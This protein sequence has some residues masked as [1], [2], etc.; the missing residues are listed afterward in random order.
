MRIV[1]HTPRVHVEEWEVPDRYAQ[2]S[3]VLVL[4]ALKTDPDARPVGASTADTGSRAVF[5][6]GAGA[7]AQ[8]AQRM[9]A[10]SAAV[11][12]AQDEARAAAV[13]AM[14]D[15]ASERHVAETLGVARNTVRGWLGK[16]R[17]G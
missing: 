12:A 16:G 15:G 2:A 4:S 6:R 14:A 8:A 13:A 7:L 11:A 17:T 1:T 9:E 3:D 10:A 5:S